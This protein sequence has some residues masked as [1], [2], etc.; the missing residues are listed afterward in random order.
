MIKKNGSQKKNRS[1]K[2]TIL[3]ERCLETRSITLPAQIRLQRDY[4]GHDQKPS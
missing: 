2:I 4:H 1:G 3:L